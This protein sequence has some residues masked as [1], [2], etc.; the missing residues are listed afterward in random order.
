M[1]LNPVYHEIY[2]SPNHWS[3]RRGYQ[4]IGAGVHISGG[5]F[6]SNHSWIMN[7]G[8]QA[9]YNCLIKRDGKRVSYVP[10][11][12][13][14]HAQGKVNKGTWPLLSKYPGV[15]PNWLALSV[16]RVGSNQ[17]L[18]TPEQL[19]ST[20]EIL[21]YWGK[22]YG[23][24]LRRPYIFGHFEIDSVDRWY[25]PG[26]GFFDALIAELSKEEGEDMLKV[27]IVVNAL[28]DILIVEPLAKHLDA[29][30]FLREACGQLNAEKVIVAGGDAKIFERPGAEVVD[31]SGTDRWETAAKVGEYYRGL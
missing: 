3:S 16:S 24:P 7:P 11:E 10:E 21:R 14:A 23:F 13:P 15:N 4:I 27:A 22:K 8:A 31:L 26:K 6:A 5:E 17:N 20:A 2:N 30:I 1:N 12:L 19:K 25:C 9:S 18:W 28:V 29:P